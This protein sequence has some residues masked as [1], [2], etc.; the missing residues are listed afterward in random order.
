MSINI[1]RA[2]NSEYSSGRT[3]IVID[4]PVSQVGVDALCS[5]LTA[6]NTD[7]T[8]PSVAAVWRDDEH[9]EIRVGNDT[10]ATLSYDEHGSVGMDAAV[11]LAR[12]FADRFGADFTNEGN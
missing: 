3:N 12:T 1:T 4:E 6:V 7:A 11:Q 5:I 2:Y 10:I 8:L 9:L